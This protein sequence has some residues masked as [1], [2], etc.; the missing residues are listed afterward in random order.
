MLRLGA[1]F[2]LRE[3]DAKLD[4]LERRTAD[5]RPVFLGVVDAMVTESLAAQF[6]TRGRHFG[7]PWAPLPPE[8]V[9]RRGRRPGHGRA[10]DAPLR[11][12]NRLWASLV[13]SGGPESLRVVSPTRYQRGTTVPYA[14]HAQQ[15]GPGRPIAPDVLPAEVTSVWTGAITRY[16]ETGALK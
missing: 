9:R 5:L 13:K 12:T 14:D 7:T 16:I 6:E 3:V 1:R 10:G 15:A 11:D 2:E 4:A 8:Y